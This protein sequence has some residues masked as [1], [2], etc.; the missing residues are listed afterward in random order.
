MYIPEVSTKKSLISLTS[1][2]DVVFILLVFFMLTSSFVRWNYIELGTS[3]QGAQEPLITEQSLIHVGFNQTYLLD[4][5][6][7]SLA[8]IKA[9]VEAA[10]K[11]DPKHP[12]LIQPVDD[13]PLGELVLVLDEIGKVA[14]SNIALVKEEL[15]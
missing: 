6:P 15:R 14:A 11:K 8:L 12:I 3:S 1:L 13:L 9:Q 5:K 10:I 4:S 7:L 2:I